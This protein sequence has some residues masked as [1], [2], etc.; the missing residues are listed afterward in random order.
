MPAFQ[1]TALNEKGR[2]QRGVLEGD[3]PRQI[4]KKLRDLGLV[5]VTVDAV[6]SKEKSIQNKSGFKLKHTISV[7]ELA[8][9]T[10][11]LATLV[12]AGLP[13]D[14]ALT[15]VA[16]QCD[17]AR[18]K[19]VVLAI[20][21]GVLEG[22]SLAESFS[23]Y[24][25]IF[26][27]LYRSM[28]AAGETSGNLGEV[29]IRL[30]DYTEKRHAIRQKTQIALLYP[31]ILSV[32]A[33]AV[34][35]GLLAFVVPNVVAQFA[36]AGQDLPTATQILIAMSDLVI[37]FWLVALLLIIATTVVMKW[38]LKK[39][40][41]KYLFDKQ[42]LALP[43]LGKVILGVNTA[44]FSRTLSIL[45]SSG[46]PLLDALTISGRVLNN[47]CLKAAVEDAANHVKEGSSLNRAL[48]ET[49]YFPPMMLHMI[50]N[51]EKSGE[52]D[53]MLER[54]AD[55]Q[56]REFE[57]LIAMALGLFEPVLILAMGGVVLF[58]VIAILLPIFELNTLVG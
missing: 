35:A 1:Y 27:S 32:V 37:N 21:G 46:V 36:T 15:A 10:R 13:L 31:T 41:F 51:G 4:R 30:A 43:A 22:K 53:N 58:I 9:V 44:R 42:L 5:A 3:T 55:N 40:S 6:S 52:L 18:L 25:H 12:Q 38:A 57:M 34:V 2:Q 47:V 19:S 24:P 28:V 48:A 56:D 54:I 45:T 49:G 8:L 39:A 50:A 14:E 20:R 11:Q 16:Q 26:D 7:A 17:K 33:I 29:L 23:D